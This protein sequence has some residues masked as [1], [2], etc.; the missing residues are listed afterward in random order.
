[1]KSYCASLSAAATK[2]LSKVLRPDAPNRIR[3]PLY[4]RA[5]DGILFLRV[6]PAF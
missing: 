6:S 4:F 1:M 2:S 5:A 3:R